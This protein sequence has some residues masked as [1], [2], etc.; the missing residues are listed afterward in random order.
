MTQTLQ[1]LKENAGRK[2]KDILIFLAMKFNI[3]HNVQW[4]VNRL[5]KTIEQLNKPETLIIKTLSEKYTLKYII[6]KYNKFTVAKL[7]KIVSKKINNKGWSKDELIKYIIDNNITDVIQ[8]ISNLHKQLK[9]LKKKGLRLLTKYFNLAQ[10]IDN[11]FLSIDDMVKNLE[12]YMN[13]NN[14]TFDEVQDIFLKLKKTKSQEMKKTIISDKVQRIIEHKEPI[15]YVIHLADLH[16]PQKHRF[17]EYKQVFSNLIEKINQPKLHGKTIVVVCGDIFHTKV[18]QRSNSIILWNYLVKEITKLY[19]MFVITGNHDYDMTT[20][21][22]DWIASTYSTNNFYH[23]NKCGEYIIN[24]ISLGISP[25]NSNQVY[26]ME[27]SDLIRIQLYHGALKGCQMFNGTILDNGISIEDFGDYDYLM[28]GDIHKLQFL[29]ETTAYSGSLV[30]QNFGE[31]IDNHGFIIWDITNKTKQFYEVNNDH[32]FLVVQITDDGYKFNK[33][34]MDMGKKDISLRLDLHIN[35]NSAI[36]EFKQFALEQGWNIVKTKINKLYITPS[37][38]KDIVSVQDQVNIEEYFIKKGH[39][40]KL[41]DNVIEKL[42][43]LHKEI[44]QSVNVLDYCVSQWR[45]KTIEFQNLFCFGGGRVNKLHLDQHGVY[46]IFANNFMG[47][48]SVLKVVKW[49]LFQDMSGIN[50]F[51]VLHKS[52]E[53]ESGYVHV[54]L[55]PLHSD[56]ILILERNIVKD[57][58][59]KSTI[60]IEH[61][62][63]RGNDIVIGKDNVNNLVRDVV[64]TYEEFELVASVNNTD[65]GILHKNANTVFTQLFNLQKFNEYDMYA[66]EQ[67]GLLRSDIRALQ[68][69]GENITS[70]PHEQIKQLKNKLELLENELTTLQTIDLTE[71]IKKKQE[72]FDKY[73]A[74]ELFREIPCDE[75][76]EEIGEIDIKKLR[77]MD[78]RKEQLRTLIRN[79]KLIDDELIK[80]NLNRYNQE[81]QLLET[82][83]QEYH[84][85]LEQQRIKINQYNQQ[86]SNIKYTDVELYT[87]MKK[88]K[89]DY[90]KTK[91]S[92]I[93][94]L[95]TKTIGENDYEA[96]RF[97]I[98]EHNYQAMINELE[99]NKTIDNKITELN[100]VIVDNTKK[101]DDAMKRYNEVTHKRYKLE[102][103]LTE[104]SAN[105]IIHNKNIQF[106][107]EIEQLTHSLT[108]MHEIKQHNEIIIQ[109][110]KAYE[111]YVAAVTHNNK[112]RKERAELEC[113]LAECEQELSERT[114]ENNSVVTNRAKLAADIE[115]LR[116]DLDEKIKTNAMQDELNK[117]LFE[118][119][120]IVELYLVYRG[121]VQEHGIPNMIL[122]DKLPIIQTDVN[123]VLKKYTNFQILIEFTGKRR[124]IEIYQVKGIE[125]IGL[126]SLSGYETLI[127]NIAFKTAIKKNCN[128]HC[129]N[130]IMID[131]VLSSVSAENYDLLPE[132]FELLETYYDVIFLITHI[133]DIKE[134]CEGSGVDVTLCRKENSSWIA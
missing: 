122:L 30:Q 63:I 125:K 47:K 24:N 80:K 132:L 58:K 97:L 133:R 109:K 101:M 16:I 51:D 116:N 48:S 113:S 88:Q 49:A 129:P 87:M 84:N 100:T 2:L 55:Q 18:Y 66:K 124:S 5:Y 76:T 106:E 119:I 29:S 28:L 13:E 126:G 69:E 102:L 54:V 7:R 26:K 78:E 114:R 6:S 105:K 99:Q 110:K 33:T 38:S 123:D 108:V 130:F 34:V 23:L 72:L 67:I 95:D 50:D 9:A 71:L 75:C 81:I 35:N 12:K 98:T 86:K 93:N 37:I 11:V 40:E 14:I 3:N 19:P 134:M 120:H 82:K 36:E 112:F 1:L 8:P 65:L 43:T 68:K 64:G 53:I 118:K 20:N 62:L 10:K 27:Q 4:T 90:I 31:S 44:E 45:I 15:Q 70:V 21:D 104:N 131:E 85:G 77:E 92:I 103:M 127:T 57:N 59:L 91:S 39:N 22:R 41:S 42:C 117:T 32:S 17:D 111:Q 94:K 74:I 52:S 73:K 115:R 46:K 79:V 121:F 56:Q 60:R 89:L 83:I 96:I 25:L 61:K 128:L 107:K